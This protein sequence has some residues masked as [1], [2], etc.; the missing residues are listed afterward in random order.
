VERDERVAVLPL[1]SIVRDIVTWITGGQVL[2]LSRSQ[3]P[4]LLERRGCVNDLYTLFR[5]CWAWLELKI[6]TRC[7]L[8]NNR[9]GNNS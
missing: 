2:H 1:L 8:R 6:F 5:I 9:S 7:I 3:Y 4:A